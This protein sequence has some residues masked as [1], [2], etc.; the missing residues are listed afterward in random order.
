[1]A[2]DDENAI[3]DEPDNPAEAPIVA[4]GEKAKL[5]EPTSAPA[6][7]ELIVADPEIVN[8][9]IGRAHV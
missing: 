3:P 7:V 6:E 9:E 2:A 4:A 8:E 1:M 5:D